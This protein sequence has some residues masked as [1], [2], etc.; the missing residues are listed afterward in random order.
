MAD[1]LSIAAIIAMSYGL[2]ASVLRNYFRIDAGLNHLSDVPVLLFAG[3]SGAILVALM[4]SMV[5][6]MSAEI[7]FSDVLVTFVP[8]L[9]G[10]IIGITVMTPPTLR[11]I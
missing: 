1:L 3:I 5:L 11:L 8:L 7:D 9:V 4:L 6:L 10:D 2:V